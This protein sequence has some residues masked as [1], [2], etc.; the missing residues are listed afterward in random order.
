MYTG[1]LI[2]DLIA[3]VERAEN[4]VR[5]EMQE[6]DSETWCAIVP[7]EVFALEAAPQLAGVA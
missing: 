2:D 5:V 7:T 1:S 3:T 4:S 6:L